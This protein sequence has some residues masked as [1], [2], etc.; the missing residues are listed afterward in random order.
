MKIKLLIIILLFIC[1]NSCKIISIKRKKFVPTK[2]T[3]EDISIS[4][5]IHFSKKYRSSFRTSIILVIDFKKDSTYNISTC[6]KIIHESGKWRIFDKK[7]ILLYDGFS[8]QL[9]RKLND[10]I[11]PYDRTGRLIYYNTYIL[12]FRNEKATVLYKGNKL[13]DGIY[14][15]TKY[16]EIDSVLIKKIDCS[17]SLGLFE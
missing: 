14:D 6:K 16:E 17:F 2:Y 11:L 3:T 12:G 7:H 13:F 9:G 10:R 5:A 4:Q 15:D 1:I 8:Y